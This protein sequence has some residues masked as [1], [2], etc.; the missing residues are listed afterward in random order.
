LVLQPQFRERFP[1]ALL[2]S[3]NVHLRHLG[4]LYAPTSTSKPPTK[5]R[6]EPKGSVPGI[7]ESYSGGTCCSASVS[8]WQEGRQPRWPR[9]CSRSARRTY[10]RNVGESRD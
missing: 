8:L 6:G 7:D 5:R 4:C 1:C 2:P 9:T 3:E 10:Y